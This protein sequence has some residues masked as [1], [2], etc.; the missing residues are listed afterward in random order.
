MKQPKPDEE[1][2]EAREQPNTREEPAPFEEDPHTTK[3]TAGKI[4]QMKDVLLAFWACS[5]VCRRCWTHEEMPEGKMARKT[6]LE[7][8]KV[9][10]TSKAITKYPR[11]SE[12]KTEDLVCAWLRR[13]ML[14]QL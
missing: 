1:H 7:T 14:K 12:G 3:E 4:D 2:V 10:S 6:S 11:K 9:R 5:E 8:W 13:A